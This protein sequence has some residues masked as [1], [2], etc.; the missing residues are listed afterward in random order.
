MW[1]NYLTVGLRSLLKNRTY[2]FI[3]V[4]GLAVGLAGCL[5]LILYVRYETSYD[6]WLPDSDQIYQVQAT[7]H[8]VGQPISASQSS[9]MPLRDALAGDFPQI[10]AISIATPSRPA[11]LRDGQPIYVEAMRVDPAFFDIFQLPFLRGSPR[12]A[13]PNVN[14]AVLTQ[15]EAIRQFGSIDVVGRT[16]TTT[17]S[18]ERRDYTVTGVIAD[19]PRNSHMKFDALLRFDPSLY[20]DTPEIFQSWGAMGQYHYVKLRPGADAA[21]MNAA[22]PDWEKRVIPPQMIDGRSAS[23]ADIMD[24][25]LVNVRDVHLGEA[26]LQAMTPGNDRRTVA[27]FSTVAALILVMACIN[28]INLSTA[29]AGQRAREVALRKVLGA[30]RKQLIVQFLGES[31]LLATL[32]ML[33]ALTLAEVFAPILGNYLDADFQLHY[34]GGD[35]IILVAVSLIG[36]V[37]ALGGLY[38]AFF[39]AR[40]QPAHVLRANKSSAEPHGTGRLRN[41]LVVAQFAIAI[42]LII[43]T[44]VVYSQTRFITTVDPGYE[45]DGLIQVKGAWRLQEAGNYD[46]ARRRLAAVPGVVAVG[47][48]NLGIAATNKSIQSVNAPGGVQGLNVGV[49]GA[50]PE[51]FHAMGMRLLAGR[52]FGERF[53]NDRVVHPEPG[54]PGG[55][56]TLVGRGLNVVVNRRAARM[57]GFREP[58]AALGQQVRTSIGGGND[59]VPCTIV[60]VVEDTRIRSARDEIEPLIFTYDPDNI[61]Q[62]IVRY[63]SSRPAQVMAGLEQG[64]RQ[65]M[66][67]IPFDAAFAEDLVAELYQRDRTR[68]AVFAGFAILAVIIS[69][70]GLFGL[71]SFAAA[72]RTKEIGIRKVL[73][74]RVRDIVKLLVWQF[75]K[76]VV[77][78][79]LIAWPIAW[80]VMRDW[81]NTFDVRVDLG[82]TPFALAG[83]LALGIAIGTIAGHAIRVARMN[84]INALRYE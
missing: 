55:A 13:L 66:P 16:I 51:F 7:W 76:P 60:G 46:A 42:G 12:Q 44:A 21:A 20:A 18:G 49:Y 37:G 78:A 77:V 81:L 61:T 53:A 11:V 14:S 24:L 29:R 48:T 36:L 15:S 50:D 68:A 57:F 82:P 40:F 64:W 19:L 62:L 65:F 70:L 47:R 22:L 5:L 79:N 75:T 38:P 58:S 2:A 63:R 30:N 28:F 34:F 4:F 31:V 67:D 41:L 39:L 33:I 74:A 84:P 1:R 32:S 25:A 83:L 72:R 59:M 27:T 35:G 43:C 54:A 9:P 10:E 6:A 8:E 56:S 69:C 45:Q 3:N 52:L 26:Q 71:A 17:T 23:Q 73:G 80:W